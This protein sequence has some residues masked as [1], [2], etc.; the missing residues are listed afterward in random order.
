MLLLLRYLL[1]Q[2]D[3]RFIHCDEPLFALASV[4]L[5]RNRRVMMLGGPVINLVETLIEREEIAYCL[6]SDLSMLQTLATDVETMLL[7]DEKIEVPK[8]SLFQTELTFRGMHYSFPVASRLAPYLVTLMAFCQANDLEF[9][10]T[11]GGDEGVFYARY[12]SRNLTISPVPT[13]RVII[14]DRPYSEDYVKE[15]ET[16]LRDSFRWGKMVMY[17]SKSREGAT[18]YASPEELLSMLRSECFNYAYILCDDPD[19]LIEVLGQTAV[20]EAATLF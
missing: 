11:G 12:L 17:S 3:I 4:L 15:G 8:A 14:L 2:R 7:H 20:R 18:H 19:A 6:A 13:D 10:W 16:F 1:V 9:G 5:G